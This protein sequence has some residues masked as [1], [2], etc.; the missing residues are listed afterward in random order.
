MIPEPKFGRIEIRGKRWRWFTVGHFQG[1]S[2]APP[3]GALRWSVS[4]RDPDDPDR[5]YWCDVPER[6]VGHLTHRTL[7]QLFDEARSG[8]GRGLPAPSRN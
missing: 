2:P 7:R 1:S 6:H 5:R 3:H 8:E 4:F